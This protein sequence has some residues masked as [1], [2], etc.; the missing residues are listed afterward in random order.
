MSRLDA[1]VEECCLTPDDDAPRLVWADRAGGE[2]G[3]FVVIQCALARGGLSPRQTGVL[4]RRERELI[5]RYGEEWSGLAEFMYPGAEGWV[6]RIEFRRGF[7]EAIVLYPDTFVRN[8]EAICHRAPL[9]RSLTM[10][11][12]GA[13]DLGP[14]P[15]VLGLPAFGK[16][17]G[18]HIVDEGVPPMHEEVDFD[19]V[20]LLLV[21]SGALAQLDSLALSWVTAKGARHL[22]ASGELEH[23]EKLWLTACEAPEVAIEIIGGAPQLKA[24]ELRHT[25]V[26]AVAGVLPPVAALS[27]PSTGS[28]IAALGRSRAAATLEKLELRSGWLCLDSLGAFPNLRVLELGNVAVFGTHDIMATMPRLRRLRVTAYRDNTGERPSDAIRPV[29]RALGAQLELLEL[30]GMNYDRSLLDELQSYVVGYVVGMNGWNS[31]LL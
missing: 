27:I 5:L 12:W 20:I 11:L 6:N 26:E 3:E 13:A 21:E 14:L 25:D 23:L 22:R 7:V 10:Q 4:L 31:P 1:L 17:R 16:L 18:L 24:L 19:E 28:A 2:R 15:A 29:A 30:Q 8:G 9:L